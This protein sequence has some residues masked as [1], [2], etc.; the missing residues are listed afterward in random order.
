MLCF[1][2]I[3]SISKLLKR[4]QISCSVLLLMGVIFYFYVHTLRNGP[5]SAQPLIQLLILL[6]DHVF[7]VLFRLRTHN[8]HLGQQMRPAA[9]RPTSG[10]DPQIIV[11]QPLT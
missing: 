3:F 7:K 4:I 5:L 6:E 2:M 8:L 11:Q 1:Q 9:H 10:G